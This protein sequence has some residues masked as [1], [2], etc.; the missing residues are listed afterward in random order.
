MTCII[1]KYLYSQNVLY[2]TKSYLQCLFPYGSPHKCYGHRSDCGTY[3][4]QVLLERLR[5]VPES[6]NFQLNEDLALCC[7]GDWYV[8]SDPQ[9]SAMFGGVEPGCGLRFGCHAD[10]VGGLE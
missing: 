2:P 3:Q 10:G 6:S 1:N 7:L 5:L 9:G 4:P 8:V